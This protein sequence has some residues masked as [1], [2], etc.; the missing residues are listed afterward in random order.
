MRFDRAQ[1][2]RIVSSSRRSGTTV[3]SIL[4]RDL[5]QTIRDW[6]SRA[7]F[8]RRGDRIRF[9]VPVNLRTKR[10]HTLPVTNALSL[11]F[12]D[13]DEVE[14]QC[15]ESLLAG[16]HDEVHG[17]GRK[18]LRMSFVTMLRVS[19]NLPGGI[20]R[21]LDPD[22]CWATCLFSNLGVLFKDSPVVGNDGQLA[23]GGLRL[24]SWDLV[25]PLR[26]NMG[27]TVCPYSYAG[28]LSIVIHYDSSRMDPSQL[29]DIASAY[30]SNI[31]QNSQID[32]EI[33]A[34]S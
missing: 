26:N 16:I 21:W 1:T 29:A 34:A 7:G 10:D 14:M 22:K 4:L 15:S 3:N 24:E 23:A 9:C 30:R 12:L 28:R 2:E 18:D 11:L 17:T 19:R 32:A 25:P 8:S 31:E 5:Y 6:R 33:L 13:R 20:K 27:V